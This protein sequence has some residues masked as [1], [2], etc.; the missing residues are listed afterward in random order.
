MLEKVLSCIFG[1]PLQR[2]LNNCEKYFALGWC[3]E[4]AGGKTVASELR[5]L[6]LY[7]C[8]SF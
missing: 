2:R 6:T 3:G 1:G 8:S 7:V 4:F 5:S